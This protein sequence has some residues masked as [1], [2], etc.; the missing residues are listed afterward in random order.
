ML[1]LAARPMK[2]IP[3]TRLV[4]P[5]DVSYRPHQGYWG[6][7]EDRHTVPIVLTLLGPQKTT[8]PSNHGFPL[9]LIIKVPIKSLC[10]IHVFRTSEDG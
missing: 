3:K 5:A 9:M 2:L 6:R 8:Y 10:G 7:I 1:V 4:T